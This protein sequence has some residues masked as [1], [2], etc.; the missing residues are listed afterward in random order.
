MTVRFPAENEPG[1]LHQSAATQYG[2][3]EL[4]RIAYERAATRRESLAIVEQ[5]RIDYDAW[6]VE[7]S[8][9]PRA[10]RRRPRPPI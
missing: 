7:P 1:D 10:T 3:Q 6:T 9:R 4:H 8:P 5:A 2:Q